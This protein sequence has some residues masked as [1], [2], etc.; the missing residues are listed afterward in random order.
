[1]SWLEKH[2]TCVLPMTPPTFD[3][4]WNEEYAK[5]IF[6]RCPYDMVFS[7]IYRNINKDANRSN[8]RILEVGCGS[9]NNIWFGATEGFSMT[10][11]DGSHEAIEYA[12][13]RLKKD[14]LS[15]DL[16]VGDFTALPY[17][18]NNFDL[19]FD[20]AAITNCGLS[21]AKRTVEEIYR[22]LIPGGKFFFNSYSELH[23]TAKSGSLTEDNLIVDAPGG[24]LAG[25]GQICFYSENQVKELFPHPWQIESI[26]H[27]VETELRESDQEDVHAE[28]RAIVLKPIGQGTV[29]S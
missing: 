21:Q 29:S 9:G 28:F 3:P 20:R 27:M 17:R 14:G 4:F 24:S 8:I 13:S 6:P 25:S 22:V 18:A 16:T 1:L 19:V 10:G 7:F 11:I 23:S 5:G 26:K 15:A 12:R 2:L